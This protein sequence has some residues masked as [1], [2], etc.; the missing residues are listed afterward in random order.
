MEA[1]IKCLGN[2]QNLGVNLDTGNTWLGGSD[3]VEFAQ[4]FKDKIYHVHWKDL[5]EEWNQQRGK[6]YGCGF[7]QIALGDGVINLKEIF[8]IV[9][10]V[11]C[12]TLEI[13]GDDNL[14][15]SRKFLESMD[16]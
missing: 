11:D 1:I 13:A 15:R 9:R 7:G 12:C 5:P 10:K 16:R 6:M 3:P 14:I 2:P 4:A 8:N